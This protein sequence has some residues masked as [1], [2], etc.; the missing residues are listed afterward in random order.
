MLFRKRNRGRFRRRATAAALVAVSS[1]V[2]LGMGALVVDIGTMYTAQND[3]Q[4]AADASALAAAAQLARP[5]EGDSQTLAVAAADRYAA[6]NTV[7]GNNTLTVL[8]EDVEFGQAAYDPVTEKFSFGG[9]YGNYDAIRV[10]VRHVQPDEDDEAGGPGLVTVPLAFAHVF[11]ETAKTL[12]AKAAAVLIPRDIAVVIDLSNSMSWDSQLRYWDRDDGGN[13]N[14]RDVWCA[15]DGPEPAK[16]YIPGSDAETEYAGDFGPTV[17]AMHEWGTALVPGSYVVGGDPGLYYMPRGQDWSDNGA[18]EQLLIDQGY[19][20]WERWALL[21]NETQGYLTP[22]ARDELGFSSRVIWQE[23]SSAGRDR[24]TVHVTSDGSG[25]TAAL[26]HLTISLPACAWAVAQSTAESQGG[27]PAL[28]VSPDP[29]TGYSGLKFDETGLGEGGVVETEWFTFEVPSDCDLGSIGIDVVSKAASDVG[30]AHQDFESVDPW[31][32]ERWEYRVAACLGMAAW[33]SGLG[34]PG[35]D[36]DSVIDV[37]EFTWNSAPAY[38]VSW[39]WLGY[40]RYVPNH[41]RSEF[42]NSY[43]LKTFVDYFLEKQPAYDE[44]DIKWATPVQPLRALKDAV[45]TMGNVITDFDAMDHV[46][47]EVFDATGTHEVDLTDDVSAVPDR[48]YQMQAGHYDRY[49]NIGDGLARAVEELTSE[50]A[51]GV[52]AKVIVLMSDGVPNRGSPDGYT[53][54]YNMA[55]EAN[56]L[57]MRIYTVSVGYGVD[58]ELMTGLATD[59]EEG[60]FHASGNPEEYTAELEEIFRTLGGRRP[61]ILIE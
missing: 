12:Q 36:S 56:N 35:G 22:P 18:L 31:N 42:Q 17:G 5:E 37:D 26:S 11:G 2:L 16:P 52:T 53:Y 34:A 19:N 15:L 43:G 38:C 58:V 20:E 39:G 1:V 23:G 33:D 9:A 61:V 6:L 40:I 55:D 41:Y 10:T 8:E 47:L 44:T 30:V 50:R 48:L 28:T 45:W 49:T 21:T 24:V 25:E 7:L 57:G 51:R 54:A 32:R 27:Y 60:H 3:L 13:S 59:G 4:I 46:S 14:L 29:Q